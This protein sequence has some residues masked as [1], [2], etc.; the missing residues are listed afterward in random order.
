[1]QILF[2]ILTV[3]LSVLAIVQKDKWKMML[4][5]II[6]N[7]CNM[8][9]YFVFGRIATAF[10]CIVASIRTFVYMF[11]SY[12]KIKPNFFWLIVF[13]TAFIIATILTWQDALDLMPLFAMLLVGYGSWQDNQTILRISYIFNKVLYMIYKAIIGA[14]ISMSV[15]AI[16]LACI[17]ICFIYY[18][19]LKKDTPILQAIFKKKTLQELANRDNDESNTKL[20]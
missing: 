3:I 11:Y 15:E 12:K 1:M 20:H 19:I 14:Y 13:E 9:M 7:V 8:A 16:N 6:S 10:I 4:I 2:Q 18:C 17:I 5:Y